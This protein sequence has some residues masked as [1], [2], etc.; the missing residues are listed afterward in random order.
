MP[1]CFNREYKGTASRKRG[2]NHQAS[3]DEEGIQ[4]ENVRVGLARYSEKREEPT[5]L[6]KKG[7][8]EIEMLPSLEREGAEIRRLTRINHP[9]A[10]KGPLKRVLEGRTSLEY[11]LT[12]S[13]G[14]DKRLER[15][16]TP[17]ATKNQVP[18]VLNDGRSAPEN[19]LR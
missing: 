15:V 11:R 3:E 2:R 5:L 9:G 1:A 10:T 16:K 4:E 12:N 7:P 6:S 13:P 18:C 8:G 14:T 19:E 17:V